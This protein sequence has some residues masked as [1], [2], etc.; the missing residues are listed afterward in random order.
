MNPATD[1]PEIDVTMTLM[2]RPALLAHTLATF[3][4]RLRGFRWQSCIANLDRPPGVPDERYAK[5]AAACLLLLNRTFECVGFWESGESRFP[6]AVRRVWAAS[7]APVVF[8]LEDDWELLCPVELD[9]ALASW[10]DGADEITLRAYDRWQRSTRFM[11]TPSLIRGDTAR[12]LAAAMPDDE[13]PEQWIR[14]IH[15]PPPVCQVWPS[16]GPPIVADTG[17]QWLAGSPWLRNSPRERRFTG[18][19]RK[20]PTC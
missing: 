5:A 1:I 12:R 7:T 18:W 6:R 4:D 3:R 14:H 2:P 20:E 10:Q 8:H 17:R 19:S 15:R 9:A 13:N 16:A 11:L